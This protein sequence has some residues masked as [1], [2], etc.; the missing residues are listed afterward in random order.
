MPIG[1]YELEVT[2]KTTAYLRLPTHPGELRGARS[3][4]LVDVMGKYNGPYVVL[5]FD[6]DG[7]L[8]GIEVVG[9]DDDEEDA[10]E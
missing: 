7:M 6:K 1:K 4:P 10:S 3:V 2:G 8:V 5:D 9:D